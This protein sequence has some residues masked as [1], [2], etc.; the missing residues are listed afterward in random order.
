MK[1]LR[2]LRDEIAEHVPRARKSV[3]QQKLRR[4]D[5]SRPPIEYL[6]SV[7][8]RLVVIYRRHERFLWNFPPV[9]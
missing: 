3:K 1:V 5:R 6:E 7:Y 9:L 8:V 2:K 4:I